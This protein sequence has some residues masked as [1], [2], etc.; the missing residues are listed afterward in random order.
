MLNNQPTMFA[1]ASPPM[2]RATRMPSSKPKAWW[3]VM[4]VIGLTIGAARRKVMAS[5]TV[6]PPTINPRARGTLPH[7]HTGRKMPNIEMQARRNTG[8]RGRY[9]IRMPSGSHN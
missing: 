4:I 5:G 7:S 1:I 3:V 2:I 6:K 8:L 9:L